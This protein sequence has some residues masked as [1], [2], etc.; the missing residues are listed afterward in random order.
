MKKQLLVLLLCLGTVGSSLWAQE[1]QNPTVEDKV[2]VKLG[3]A[4]RFNYN[5]SSWKPNQRKRG[6]DFGYDVFRIDGQISYKKWLIK[7]EQR[8][9]SQEFGGAFLKFG[10]A[11]YNINDR[12]HVKIGLIPAYF[13]AQ[14]FNSHSWF[15][16][17]PYYLGF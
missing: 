13:G 8:F 3:G 6:G 10:W 15:F 11:Q 14:Q 5:Y 7:L 16:A 17:L 12:S 1:E 4:L 9:Y 2:Q